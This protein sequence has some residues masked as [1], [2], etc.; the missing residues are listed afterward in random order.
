MNA[1]LYEL[2]SNAALM[3]AP[4]PAA[5]AG[6]WIDKWQTLLGAGVGGVLGVAGALIVAHTQRRREQRVAASMVL[7]DLM[8]LDAAGQSLLERL[9]PPPDDPSM[10]EQARAFFL[11]GWVVDT[12]RLLAERRPKL[13]ALHTPAIGQLS[14]VD[15]RLYSHL[16]QCQMVHRQFEDAME[17]LKTVPSEPKNLEL[18]HQQLCSDWRLCVEHAALARFWLEHLV[19]SPWPRWIVNARLKRH[20][21]GLP[22]Y[23]VQPVP[24]PDEFVKR[25]A[26]LLQTGRIFC[27]AAAGEA[28]Q[29]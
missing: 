5:A 1:M 17:S 2:T 27:P 21:V 13:F 25:S 26:H 6:G 28:G 16:F 23:P 12:L 9:G 24:S 15:A 3:C 18:R 22:K 10:P 7:P 20:L 19:F 14:D 8:Q 29:P 4:V 11:A